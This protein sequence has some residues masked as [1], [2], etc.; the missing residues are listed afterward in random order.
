MGLVAQQWTY[1]S[2]REMRDGT[3]EERPMRHTVLDS[4]R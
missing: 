4:Q 2:V 1:A 3:K